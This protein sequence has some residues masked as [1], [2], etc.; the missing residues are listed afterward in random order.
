[1]LDTGLPRTQNVGVLMVGYLTGAVLVLFALAPRLALAQGGPPLLTDDPGTPGNGQSELNIAFT[2]EKF[3]NESQVEAPLIDF[4]Y[5]IGE[6]IQVKF[7]IPW[8]IGTES[9]QPTQSGLGTLLLGFK[10]RFLD[11]NPSGIDASFYPQVDFATSAHARQAGLVPEGMELLLPVELQKD[12]G[13]ISVNVEWGYLLREEAEEEWRW[14]IA[15]GRKI[16]EEIQILGEVHGE[17]AKNFD[18]GQLVFNLGAR[19]QLSHLNSILVSAGRGI[20][21]E[22]RGEPGFIGYLGLQFNF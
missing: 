14:G 8:L 2:V 3:R 16:T 7:E 1:M 5:G 12:L 21:G 18:R 6:R 11:E 13:V 22:T 17:S 15:L 10:Y 20:R 4:N 19:I 9:S